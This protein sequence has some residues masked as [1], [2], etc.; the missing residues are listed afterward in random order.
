M[1][2]ATSRRGYPSTPFAAMPSGLTR[3]RVGGC[4]PGGGTMKE[5][6]CMCGW[7]CRGTDEE[8]IEQVQAHGREVHGVAA[9]EEEILALA[10]EVP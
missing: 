3:P 5:V 1:F 2:V 9:T 6:T 8:V 10:V 7:Q 4:S